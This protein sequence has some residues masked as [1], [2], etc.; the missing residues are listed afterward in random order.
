MAKKESIKCF[1]AKNK[2]KAAS[3]TQAN[4]TYTRNTCLAKSIL[5]DSGS[6]EK[7]QLNWNSVF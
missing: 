2:F 5:W 6:E 7:K 1:F 4:S 3:I